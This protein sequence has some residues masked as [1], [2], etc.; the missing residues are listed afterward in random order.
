MTD[1][2]G[3]VRAHSCADGGHHQP[4]AHTRA[5]S[6]EA[7]R[8]A[9]LLFA[10]AGHF[11]GTDHNHTSPINFSTC[12]IGCSLLPPLLATSWSLLCARERKERR[13]SPSRRAAKM[14]AR[15]LWA[16]LLIQAPENT[17]QVQCFQSPF[18]S[19]IL[20]RID[21][22]SRSVS[23]LCRKISNSNFTISPELT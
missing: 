14:R 9:L 23:G 3:R 12:S 21:R 11:L 19:F 4:C 13:E 7:G 8:P 16:C 6:S 2:C 20:A 18:F 10:W 5:N 1:D 15:G 22:S 17:V